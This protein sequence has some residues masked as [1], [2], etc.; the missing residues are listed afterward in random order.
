MLEPSAAA[1]CTAMK[2]DKY[3][4]C[5]SDKMTLLLTTRNV[6]LIFQ[7]NPKTGQDMYP[8]GPPVYSHEH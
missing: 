6:T 4:Q 2:G 1:S 8:L 7:L 3:L 5:L